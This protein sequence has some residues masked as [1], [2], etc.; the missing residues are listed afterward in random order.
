MQAVITSDWHLGGMSKT[1]PNSVAQQLA[2]IRKPFEWCRANRV[3]NIFV[4]GD[5]SHTPH[6]DNAALVG[7]VRLFVEFADLSIVVLAG[8]HDVADSTTTSLD[9]LAEMAPTLA[10]LT[11][12][13]RKPTRKIV[14][15]VPVC[16]LPWPHMNVP[17]KA[18]QL[19]MVHAEMTGAV[20]DNGHKLKKTKHGFRLRKGDFAV[21]GHLHTHQRH[22][23]VVW[24]G[25]LYQSKFGENF[26]KGWLDVRVDDQL[27]VDCKFVEN[28]PAW[29]L[30]TLVANCDD[31]YEQ[32]ASA[33]PHVKFSVKLAAGVSAAKFT[34]LPNVV[35]VANH[36]MS[37]ELA[38]PTDTAV[39]IKPWYGLRRYLEQAGHDNSEV[40]AALKLVK[41]IA[42][43]HGF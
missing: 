22:G 24:C 6:M 10:N 9:V 23:D 1:I 17:F 3:R 38:A 35:S 8:N 7:L 5:L 42:L 4:L 33:P 19:V 15:G 29:E 36:S 43:E 34:E 18:S 32:I 21:S 39:A 41:S 2:E 28:T 11:V 27:R 26:P 14:D 30:R 40:L 16:W 20:G 13:N 37:L 31:D 25:S 12:I